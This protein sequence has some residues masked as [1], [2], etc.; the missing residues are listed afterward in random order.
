V[1]RDDLPEPPPISRRRDPEIWAAFEAFGYN[2]RLNVC[3]QFLAYDMARVLFPKKGKAG[4]PKGSGKWDREG[5]GLNLGDLLVLVAAIKSKHPTWNTR[6][7]CQE[8]R[9]PR[10]IVHDD[11]HAVPFNPFGHIKE[12]TLYSRLTKGRKK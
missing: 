5:E 4:R 1:D 7:I 8:L 6:R 2:P 3:W 12:T 10:R 11:G 9:K